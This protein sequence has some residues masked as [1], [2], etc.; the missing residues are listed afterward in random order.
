MS[1]EYPWDES[2]GFTISHNTLFGNG[3]NFY[4]INLS[5]EP[6]PLNGLGEIVDINANGDSCDAYYNILL[7]PHFVNPDSCD[8]HLAETSPCRNAG[9]DIGLPFGGHAPEIGAFEF[10]PINSVNEVSLRPDQLAL[11]PNYPNPFNSQTRIR[12]T[13]PLTS[14]VRIAIYDVLGRL[15]AVLTEGRLNS[16][17]Y[18]ISYNADKLASGVYFVRLE[19]DGGVRTQAIHLIK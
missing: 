14:Q 3:M 6:L 16:S 1:Q 8:F 5:N 4:S 15:R 2:G 11:F 18:S 12:F 7:D 10:D 9:F 13:L 17:P 19:T